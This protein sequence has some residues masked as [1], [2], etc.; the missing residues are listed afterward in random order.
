VRRRW[1]AILG[2]VR[3][4]VTPVF[5]LLAP[6]PLFYLTVTPTFYPTVT[7]TEVHPASLPLF[8]PFSS[9]PRKRESIGFE[10]RSPDPRLGV[11]Y[12]KKC[13][14][15]RLYTSFEDKAPK[16]RIDFPLSLR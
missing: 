5:Y 10:G 3:V 8:I 9:L 6:P 2:Y 13:Q 12:E 4:L 15:A 7:P 16:V 11:T 14:V 1:G